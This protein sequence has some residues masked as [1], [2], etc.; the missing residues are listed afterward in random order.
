TVVEN[1]GASGLT[2]YNDPSTPVTVSINGGPDWP[3]G[4]PAVSGSILTWTP[5]EISELAG[6]LAYRQWPLSDQTI[7]ITF[8]V[9]RPLGSQEGLVGADRDIQARLTYST[10][11]ETFPPTGPPIYVPCPGNPQSATTSV[12]ELP[13]YEPYPVVFKRGRNV[14]AGQDEGEYSQTVYG[15]V[16][17]DVIWRIQIRNDGTANLQDLRLD[18]LMESGN[19]NINY[20]CPSAASASAIAASD[21]VGPGSSGCRLAGNTINN[22]DVDNPFGN[23]GNES[24]DIVD[25]PDGQS[26]YVYLVGKIPDASP[27]G[28]CETDRKDNTVSDVQWGCQSEP[29]PAGGIGSTSTGLTPANATATLSTFSNTNLTTQ[30]RFIGYGSN[31]VT[32]AKGRVRIT[33]TNNTGATVTDLRLK[34]DL[35]PEYVVD[36]TFTPTITA[37]G[38]YGYYPGL[39]NRIQW[40]NP[41]ANPLNNNI[42]EFTL[43]SSEANP[44]HPE[45]DNM[46]RNGDRLVVTFGIILIRPQSYDKEAD[47]D[48]QTEGPGDGT[49]P[50]HAVDLNDLTN[51]LEIDFKNFCTPGDTTN[52]FVTTHDPRPEDLDIN[53]LNNELVFILTGDPAQRLPLTVVLTNNGGH[54]ADDYTAYVTFG[55]T[56]NVVSWPSGCGLTSN[57][58]PLD[59][60]QNPAAIPPGTAV[61]ECTGPSIAP[62]GSRNFAFEVVKSTDSADI[63]AD[64]LTFRAD[65][66]GEIRDNGGNLLT[67]PAINVPPRSDGGSDRANNYSLDGLR[68][69][70][71]GFNLLKRQLGDCTENNPPPG[72][73]D[74]QVQIGEEC[75]YH[76]DT[77]GWFGFKTPGFTFIAVQNIEVDDELPNGQG[78]LRSGDSD[79]PENTTSAILGISRAPS[80]LNPLDEGWVTWFF[81]AGQ[82]ITE[83]DHW[84]RR[85]MTTRLLNDPVNSS[86]NPNRHAAFSTNTL[87]STFDAIFRDD[88][89][90]LNVTHTLGSGTV[91]YPRVDVRRISLTVTEPQLTVVKEVCNE[92]LYGSGTA[93]TNFVPL[94]DDGD[95]Y[96][97]YI[98]RLTLTNEASSSGVQRAP[99]YDVT[100]TDRLDASDLAYVLPF[101]SDGLDNDGDGATDETVTDIEGSIRNNV[102]PPDGIPGVITFSHTH[103]NALLR[104]DA[105]DSVQLYYRV[106]FDDD[107]APL[108][109]FTNTAVATYDS[110]EGPFGNQTV[111]QLANGDLPEIGGARVYTSPAASAAVQIIPVETQPKRIA[112]LSNT[113]L[114]GSSPQGVSIGEEIHYRLNTL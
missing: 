30:V 90:G 1:L 83:I 88:T 53:F 46:L 40:D 68:A 28:S 54:S 35:P 75:K 15:N 89:T 95:A 42:P 47:L 31:P 86:G 101:A 107:A 19:I 57:P 56:M 34:N 111:P 49:D 12:D 44:N 8:P 100:V 104:I 71:V 36:S 27:N 9:T 87:N 106:D 103:S 67:Y 48:V 80:P 76:I 33:I 78:W 41:D 18:D 7:A 98:Y 79:P 14:D 92:S 99:A 20:I 110:L 38:A 50:N 13:L 23:P 37:A 2:F 39:T 24:P 51:T 29:T 84:F 65:V 52:T 77:G 25:V 69:R 93:C 114:G 112:A 109:T 72:N 55:R 102:I 3:T 66:I 108:Q 11:Y 45:Q 17:D 63:A 81:N 58:P 22:F 94:A 105:G 113:P 64:D 73:P 74:L 97:S 70:V 61:Y 59:E 43:T 85:D 60:W 5:S 32:G 10:E 16:K 82:P 6:P 21:G 62:G 91:G 4:D 26:A 96:N